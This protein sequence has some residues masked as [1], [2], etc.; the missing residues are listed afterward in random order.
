MKSLIILSAQQQCTCSP[1]ASTSAAVEA[2]T[3]DP[4]SETG[5]VAQFD[6]VQGGRLRVYEY[7]LGSG[8]SVDQPNLIASWIPSPSAP[9]ISGKKGKLVLS[10]KYLSEIDALCLVLS[11]GE[12]VLVKDP[13]GG[14][15]MVVDEESDRREIVGDVEAGILAAI[16]SPDEQLLSI[17][18]GSNTLLVLSSSFEVLSEG[19]LHTTSFGENAPVALGW[20]SKTTQFHGSVGKSAAQSQLSPDA[21]FPASV[22]GDDGSPSISWRGDSAFF[23][24]G[25]LEERVAGEEKMRVLRVFDRVGTLSSTA[26][27]TRGL[28]QVVSWQPSGSLIAAAQMGS[29]G[30][31]M[32]IFFERNGLRRYEFELRNLEVGQRVK[33]LRWS[34]D[35][36]LLAVWLNSPQ[37][38]DRVQIWHRN[39]YHWYLKLNLTTLH[40][41]EPLTAMDW[42]LEDSMRLFLGTTSG[43]EEFTFAWDTFA[44]LRPPPND[45]AS[46]AVVDGSSLLLTPFRLQN[47]PPPGASVTLALTARPHVPAQVIFFPS[48]SHAG[49]E[50]NVL[51]PNGLL[52]VY[53]WDLILPAQEGRKFVRGEVAEPTFNRQVQ[54]IEDGEGIALQ[55]AVLERTIAVLVRYME[56]GELGLVLL[57]EGGEK[58]RVDLGGSEIR[59][60]IA[61]EENGGEEAGFLLQDKNGSILFV[62]PS[63]PT[64]S[65]ASPSDHLPFPTFCP[66]MQYNP[67]PASSIVG[68][69]ASGNIYA[70]SRLVATNATSFTCT[71]EF[72]IFTTFTHEARFV[73]FV[74]LAQGIVNPSSIEPI[75]GVAKEEGNAGGLGVK[76]NVE[77][78]SQIVTLS[79]SLTTLV[80]QMPRGNLETVCPRPLVLRIVRKDLDSH[81]YGPAFLAC[82]RQRIDLNILYDH[83][84]QGFSDN[85]PEFVDQVKDV[86]YLNLFLSGLKNEDVNKTMYKPIVTAP[87]GIEKISGSTTNKVNLICDLVR[88]ELE[89]RDVFHYANTVLTAHVRK[90]PPDYEA[91]LKVLVDLKSRDAERAEEAVTYIIFLSDANKLYDLALGL[92][93]FPLVLLIAQHSQKDPREYLPFLRN[94]RQLETYEQRYTIDDYLERHDSAL[95]N[96]AQIKPERFEAAVEYVKKYD[97]FE[98]A[99]QIW[100]GDSA[101]YKVILTANAEYLMEHRKPA[102][103]GLLFS[104]G[105]QPAQAMAAYKKANAWQELFNLALTERRP[106]SEIKSLA[107]EVAENLKAKRKFAEAGRVLLEYGR[108][109]D[110]AVSALVEGTL[111]VEAIRLTSLYSKKDL[112]ETHIKPGAFDVQSRIVDD[113]DELTEQVE[114]QVERLA[115]LKVRRDANPDQ[116]FC[117]DTLSAAMEGVELQPDGASDA[118][119]AFTR[120]TVAGQS[121]ATTQVSS[122]TSR[123][124]R[125]GNLKK[126]AG[127]KGSVYEETYLLRSIKKSVEDKLGEIQGETAALLPV[128]LQLSSV[129]HRSAAVSLQ[130]SLSQLEAFLA[131]QV[132]AVWRWREGEWSREVEEELQAKDRGEFIPKKEE[133]EEE[134][135]RV[136]RPKIAANRWRSSILGSSS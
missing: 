37:G 38:G 44:S 31:G 104:L 42:H 114:K 16:W 64:D 19:P 103:A 133:E 88:K 130:S 132:E 109:V 124:R 129:S 54:M 96:L 74:S 26:E 65:L 125:R 131:D 46:V 101:K 72:L 9:S 18:T 15:G 36:R 75:R 113:I 82:R 33:E 11:N 3:I 14:D 116:Y 61:G 21:A 51:Y 83:D 40:K 4:A 78:G 34:E 68:L 22:D 13:M 23:V 66:W 107:V 39:N 50:I 1:T 91:A 69:S 117:V 84:P 55:I 134:L 77:R 28:D 43:V 60:L 76:R 95:R 41:D 136:V 12:I 57:K 127:K 92:Y 110:A 63:I 126:A 67:A 128:L 102:E 123:S 2:T 47:V 17:I 10:F 112:I 7:K 24:V 100:S 29:K 59:K 99:L 93:D 32:I 35:S 52:E 108:D 70:S 90:Q 53:D 85:L 5:W 8:S 62:S 27:K 135:K 115:E 86:D 80:L 120:Y 30:D 106:A 56:S 111:L 25:S 81:K 73:P 97:L 45:D 118:G 71:P 87:A 122:K 94:L 6:N 79:P 119:T 121:V 105:G 98:T 20:G 49:L 89:K 48:P 58:R